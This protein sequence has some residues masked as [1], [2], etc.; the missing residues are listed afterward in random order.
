MKCTSAEAN[1][2]LK[3]LLDDRND[4]LKK[5]EEI[6]TFKAATVEKLEDARPEYDYEATQQEL[7]EIDNRVRT[8]KH[9]INVFNLTQEIP[10]TGMTIDQVL[11]YLPQ[12]SLRKMKLST[13]KQQQVKKR[14]EGYDANSH[15]IE[16]T[17]ANYDPAQAEADY[18]KV[19]DELG[20]IQNA[21]DLVNSTVQFEIEL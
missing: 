16:Y 3:K 2:M 18:N 12:L 19:S 13:M 20:R 7:I 14:C 1:K 15:F 17:Y 6:R 9:A 10:G 4:I 5:E 21:L 8:I 11:V